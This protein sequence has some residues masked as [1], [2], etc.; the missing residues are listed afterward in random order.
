MKHT[1]SDHPQENLRLKK[2][3]FT[4]KKLFLSILIILALILLALTLLPFGKGN[5]Q[6]P[7]S[8]KFDLSA[9][10]KT[11]ITGKVLTDPTLQQGFAFDNTNNH[12]Y[13]VQITNAGQ[14]L[15]TETRTYGSA[16]RS[17]KG[18]LTVTKLSAEGTILGNMYLIGFGHGVSIGVEP[19]G[20]TAYL[21]TEVDAVADKSEPNNGFGTK[22]ARFP[23]V[24]NQ[25][26][27]NTDPS[28]TK[29]APVSGADRTT[30]NI[31]MANGLLTMR[32]RLNETLF[33]FSVFNLAEVKAGTYKPLV[34]VDQPTGLGVFQGFASYGSYLYLLD[35]TAYNLNTNPTGNTYI[36]TVNLNTG[37]Q[38]DR[39]MINAE[40]SLLF[41]EPEGMAIQIVGTTVRLCFG[42]GSYR[43]SIDTRKNANIFYKD[44]LIK[45]S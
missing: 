43:S 23:F 37:V 21:W 2:S 31:D 20:T 35:G 32:Y 5:A 29:F 33:H 17:I 7:V 26:L 9:T 45:G 11:L 19:V 24:D 28:I 40:N 39:A 3:P 16:E 6:I 13:M 42:F 30:V 10:D 22:I 25:V 14:K 18:D 4:Q 8:K 38:V 1:Q 12:I 36:T 44:A 41:R 15:G 27:L 34:T